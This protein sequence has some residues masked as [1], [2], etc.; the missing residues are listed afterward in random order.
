[1]RK[2]KYG[3]ELQKHFFFSRELNKRIRIYFAMFPEKVI[4]YNELL[5]DAVRHFLDAKGV[6]DEIQ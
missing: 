6:P 4:N 2:A 5:N 1:M 3:R